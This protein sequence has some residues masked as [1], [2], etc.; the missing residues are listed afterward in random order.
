M[1]LLSGLTKAP[2]QIVKGASTGPY[3]LGGL[4]LVEQVLQF[5]RHRKQRPGYPTQKPVAPMKRIISVSSEIGEPFFTRS[6][7]AGQRSTQRKTGS[8]GGSE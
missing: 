2:T 4:Q 8:S 7:A 6:V 1:E 5:L 3:A